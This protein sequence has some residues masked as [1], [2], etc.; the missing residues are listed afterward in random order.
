M[1]FLQIIHSWRLIIFLI[2]RGPE[3]NFMVDLFPIEWISQAEERIAPHIRVTPLT[4]DADRGIYF[5]WENQQ[6]TGSF[7]AR[8]A[9]NKVLSLEAW[10]QQS[11]I[12]AASAGNHGQGVAL[13]GKLVGAPVTVFASQN[14]SPLKID[15][16]RALG[17]DVHL[18]PG[19]YKQ[20][21]T[22]GI[23]YAA[24]NNKIWVSPYND[25]QASNGLDTRGDRPGPCFW[26]R[27]TGGNCCGFNN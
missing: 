25:A 24:E 11:G 19:G 3:I 8:G 23:R 17:A 4:Y 26:W 6:L 20:A 22:E 14:A 18:V 16:M 1:V 13:A 10:E 2:F 15:K 9:F 12:V 27:S 21:E 7:K 5:K